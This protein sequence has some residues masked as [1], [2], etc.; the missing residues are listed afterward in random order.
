MSSDS[1]SF[2]IGP[3]QIRIPYP[4]G[5]K[6]LAVCHRCPWT[7][8]KWTETECRELLIRH[9]ESAHID[10][11]PAPALDRPDNRMTATYRADQ[12]A[13]IPPMADRS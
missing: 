13:P 7:F 4:D 10:P 3:L 2:L 6:Y 5:T 8:H 11:Y 9:I 12:P 1:S